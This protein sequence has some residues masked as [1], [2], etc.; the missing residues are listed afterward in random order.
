MVVIVGVNFFLSSLPRPSMNAINSYTQEIRQSVLH[1]TLSPKLIWQW[2]RN[3]CTIRWF[4]LGTH[5][6]GE[7]SRTLGAKPEHYGRKSWWTMWR[8][9]LGTCQQLCCSLVTYKISFANQFIRGCSGKM[10]LLPEGCS[11]IHTAKLHSKTKINRT[12]L[13]P[14]KAFYKI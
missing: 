2:Q 1:Q 8:C 3:H 7:P 4:S 10:S 11:N 6:H 13:R 9:K 12:S 5:I 14:A